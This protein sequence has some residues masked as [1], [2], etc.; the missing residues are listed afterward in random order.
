MPTTIE[1]DKSWDH[2]LVTSLIVFFFLNFVEVR[3]IT[4]SKRKEKKKVGQEGFG[5]S[6][7]YER[8]AL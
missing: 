4:R 2:C 7:A 5:N 1:L 3:D 6:N 8:R